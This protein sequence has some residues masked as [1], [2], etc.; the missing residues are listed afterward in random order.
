M[1]GVLDPS[2]RQRR[3][4]VCFHATVGNYSDPGELER[5]LTSA[6]CECEEEPSALLFWHAESDNSNGVE[7]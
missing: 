7:T 6:V 1:E 4:C 2:A 3:A 5:V